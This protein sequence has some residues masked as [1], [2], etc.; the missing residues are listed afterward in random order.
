MMNTFY[1]ISVLGK[2]ERRAIWD[3]NAHQARWIHA[4]KRELCSSGVLPTCHMDRCSRVTVVPWWHLQVHY[5]HVA[6]EQ[7]T[8]R[9]SSQSCM[10][11]VVPWRY[12][13][14]IKYEVPQA[15][16]KHH[17]VTREPRSQICMTHVV[18]WRRQNFLQW[19]MLLAFH[20][21]KRK[22]KTSVILSVYCSL[23]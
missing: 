8:W 14:F 5:Q 4:A 17:A 13:R 16:L 12:E 19:S 9:P 1:M 3:W 2:M 23:K 21:I 7:L 15:C 18:P 10:T 20:K 22:F 6:Y 11:L